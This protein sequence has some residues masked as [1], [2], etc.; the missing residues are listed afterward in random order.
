MKY[1]NFLHRKRI[2]FDLAILVTRVKSNKKYFTQLISRSLR[3][4]IGQMVRYTII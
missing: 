2:Y 3:V 1:E 4:Y